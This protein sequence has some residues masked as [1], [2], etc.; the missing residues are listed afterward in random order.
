M[1]REQRKNGNKD[2]D[3]N[4]EKEWKRWLR[5]NKDKMTDQQFQLLHPDGVHR[6]EKGKFA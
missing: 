6:L 4:S 5:K 3:N 1:N 2:S